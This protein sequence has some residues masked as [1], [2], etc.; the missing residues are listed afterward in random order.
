[1][2]HIL[3]CADGSNISQG[4]IAT[5]LA[6]KLVNRKKKMFTSMFS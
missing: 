2:T 4:N 1:M 6:I 3:P 5:Y